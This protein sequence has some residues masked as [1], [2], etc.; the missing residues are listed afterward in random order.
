[1]PNAFAR[2]AVV[3]LG[4]AVPVL[5]LATGC[6][7]LNKATTPTPAPTANYANQATDAY[8]GAVQSFG[9]PYAG[10][11]EVEFRNPASNSGTRT[12]AVTTDANGFFEVSNTVIPTA[13]G[14]CQFIWPITSGATASASTANFT[15]LYVSDPIAN[16]TVGKDNHTPGFTVDIGWHL[17]PSLGANAT[18][19]LASKAINFGFSSLSSQTGVAAGPFA[20]QIFLKDSAGNEWSSAW[21]PVANSASTSI[22]WDGTIGVGANA[23]GGSPAATGSATYQVKWQTQGVTD[24]SKAFGYSQWIPVTLQ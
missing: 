7:L 19:S 8:T 20:Y 3:G 18:A 6:P 4:F 10:M 12:A 21:N 23:P 14:S 11:T 13:S 16:P 15:D 22:T 2:R 5:A 1:M 17:N 9:Q 24:G